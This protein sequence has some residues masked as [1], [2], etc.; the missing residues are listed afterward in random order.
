MLGKDERYKAETVLM[1][2]R[3]LFSLRPLTPEELFFVVV[4]EVAPHLLGPWDRPQ[5][6]S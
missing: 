2:Q 4:T 1:L 6:T 3:V 5:I